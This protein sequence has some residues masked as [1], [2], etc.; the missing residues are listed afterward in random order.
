MVEIEALKFGVYWWRLLTHVSEQRGSWCG[1][2]GGRYRTEGERGGHSV[3][4]LVPAVSCPDPSPIL[5][6]GPLQAQDF[7]SEFS[8]LFK[9][10]RVQF[11][12][13]ALKVPVFPTAQ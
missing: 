11:L 7:C 2:G 3:A 13:L 6:Q 1:R 8:C 5:V 4:G 9:E 10:V 12:S